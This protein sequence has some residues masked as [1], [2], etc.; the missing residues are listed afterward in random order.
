MLVGFFERHPHFATSD[1]YLTS[2]SYGGHYVPTL[3]RYIVDHDTTGMNLVGLAVGNPYT[4]PLENMRGM[5]GAT[6]GGP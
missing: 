6:G 3:A 4:D 1:L 5:V 2:E